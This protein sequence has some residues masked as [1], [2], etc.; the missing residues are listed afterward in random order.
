MSAI[1]GNSEKIYSLGVLP[2]VTRFDERDACEALKFWLPPALRCSFLLL[3]PFHYRRK[4]R[5]ML[6]LSRQRFGQ[7]GQAV[8]T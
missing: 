8:R 1:W 3:Q 5:F 6:A 4:S 2:P 7:L